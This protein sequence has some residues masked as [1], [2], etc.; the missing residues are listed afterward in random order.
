MDE[1]SSLPAILR[2]LEKDAYSVNSP[3]EEAPGYGPGM[4]GILLQEVFTVD[5]QRIGDAMCLGQV[6]ENIK[7]NAAHS[8]AEARQRG[9]LLPV[10]GHLLRRDY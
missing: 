1:A 6:Q 5:I 2:L 8:A 9:T 10:L 7:F 4:I 3:E